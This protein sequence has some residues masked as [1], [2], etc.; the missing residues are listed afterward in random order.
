VKFVF[1]TPATGIRLAD[2]AN[3]ETCTTFRGEVVNLG[4]L[5]TLVQ[6]RLATT[7]DVTRAS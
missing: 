4:T 1:K 5:Q 2:D 7:M 6:T 3:F